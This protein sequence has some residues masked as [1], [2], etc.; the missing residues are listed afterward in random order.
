[1]CFACIIST[2]E[3]WSSRSLENTLRGGVET[4]VTEVNLGRDI[5]N[6]LLK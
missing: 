1:M 3:V 6:Q 5:Y 2:D 4:N